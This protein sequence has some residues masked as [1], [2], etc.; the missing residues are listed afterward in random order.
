MD[1]VELLASKYSDTEI[2]ELA[3]DMGYDDNQIKKILK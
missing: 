2:Q 1:E 3:K